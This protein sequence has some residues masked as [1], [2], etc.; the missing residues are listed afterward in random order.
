[1][2]TAPGRFLERVTPVVLTW[3]E[4]PNIE[5]VLAKLA[6]AREIVVVDSG[7]D[8]GTLEMLARNPKV[9]CV[10][11]PFDRHERQWNFA[12][13]ETGIATDWVLALDADYVLSD[14]LVAEMA[15]LAPDAGTAGYETRFRYC[16]RGRPLRGS[17]YPPVTTLF[18]RDRGRYEQDGHTQR[19]ALDGAVHRLDGLVDHDDRK[20]LA[21]WLA[22]QERYAT[23]EAE[24]P[25][26]SAVARPAHPGPAAPHAGDHPL[27]R[28]AL[29][30]CRPRRA[31]RRPGRPP[32]R[33]AARRGRGDTRPE[34]GRGKPGKA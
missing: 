1:M 8:D 6:W 20:P 28:A 25:P 19:I 13:G 32:L 18:R 24:S 29:L 33:P 16:V 26:A 7:S 14:A 5:R 11:R 23:L 12:L 34:A 4:A 2:T 27:A 3:N 21:R 15:A 22:S 10:H 17:L 31:A 30:P 9:R